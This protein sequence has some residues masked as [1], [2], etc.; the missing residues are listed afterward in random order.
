VI[1]MLEESGF[2]FEGRVLQVE[3]VAGTSAGS[4]RTC[5]LFE[6]LDVIKGSIA[7]NTIEL[8]FAG[9]T[10]GDVTRHV[11]GMVHPELGETGTYFVVSL[12]DPLIH[13]LY[14]WSQGH[15]VIRSDPR[16]PMDEVMTVDGRSVLAIDPAA[17]GRDTLFS[18]GVA[19][20]VIVTE[21]VAP[22]RAG[23]VGEGEADQAA[24]EAASSTAGNAQG[25]L[26]PGEF[27]AQLRA[28]LG[29]GT[30]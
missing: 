16:I 13:P 21:P 7:G 4:I 26:T 6:I 23:A 3:T 28:L 24:R 20:G 8:C 18:R 29:D 2:V 19:R 30:Q 10:L 17:L 25:A 11:A 22:A 27:K 5:A 1:E 12:E 14:G 15:F 9:G